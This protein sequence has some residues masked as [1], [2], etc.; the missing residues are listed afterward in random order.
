M[1][2]T[3]IENLNDKTKRYEVEVVCKN[4]SIVLSLSDSTQ[5]SFI[6]TINL[7][8]GLGSTR[9]SHGASNTVKVIKTHRQDTSIE[10]LEYLDDG[11]AFY[12]DLSLC[13]F[14]I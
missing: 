2:T 9:Y 6:T 4:S 8:T 14:N 1:L 12:V 11:Q 7:L 10:A 5:Y 3:F 13:F